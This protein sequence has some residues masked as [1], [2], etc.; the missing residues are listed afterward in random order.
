M[1]EIP[2]IGKGELKKGEIQFLETFERTHKEKPLIFREKKLRERVEY[3][4]DEIKK[5]IED[6]PEVKT[7]IVSHPEVSLNQITNI[8]SQALQLALN[9]S[10]EEGL[11]FINKTNNPYLIDAFHDLLTGHFME[12]LMSREE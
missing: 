9:E 8:L 2:K 4:L 6:L 5:R 12:L 11:K 3:T 1:V 7:E 10:I